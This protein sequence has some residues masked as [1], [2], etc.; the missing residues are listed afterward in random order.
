[1]KLRLEFPE[2]SAARKRM[3]ANLATWTPGSTALS[4]RQAILDVLGRGVE[5]GGLGDVAIG[6]GD[7]ITYKGE[8]ALLYIKATGADK[9]TLENTP[10]ESMRFHLADCKTLDDMRSKG[11]FERYVVTNRTDGEFLVDWRDRKT[12]DSGEIFAKL[13]VCRHCLAKLNWR[14]YRNGDG[15]RLAGGGIQERQDVWEKFQISEFLMEYSTFFANRPSRTDVEAPVN[16]YVKDWPQ[17]SEQQ[18]QRARWRCAG[19]Q[20]NLSMH[21]NLLHCHHKSG[22]VTDNS[23][24]NLAVL[25]AICHADQPNHQHMKVTQKDR[26]IILDAR[27]RGR[28]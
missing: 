17:I 15:L 12:G 4:P 18:R 19:C 9:W 26:S 25:C 21:P 2:L 5:I 28:S 10:E 8:Q 16:D 27:R 3:G 14:G 20:A 11:R 7:L 22:V 23:D 13:K 6:P 24:L 1:M